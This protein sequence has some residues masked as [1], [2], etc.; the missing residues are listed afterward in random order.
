LVKGMSADHLLAQLRYAEPP[1]IARVQDARVLLDLR[2]VLAQQEP[3]IV[4]A[5]RQIAEGP[6]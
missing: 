6:K 2:T 5:L 3:A 1:I 4:S